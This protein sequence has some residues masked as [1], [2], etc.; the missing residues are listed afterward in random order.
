MDGLWPCGRKGFDV[1]VA[2]G[3]CEWDRAMWINRGWVV[4]VNQ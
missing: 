2:K 3:F 4:I 1:W